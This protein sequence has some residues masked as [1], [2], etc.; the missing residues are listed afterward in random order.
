M[1]DDEE[2][3]CELDLT[4]ETDD[5]RRGLAVYCDAAGVHELR[6]LGTPKAAVVFGYYDPEGREAFVED[7]AELSGEA[8]GVYFTLNPVNPVLLARSVNRLRRFGKPV[9]TS[10]AEII[11]RRW[12]PLDFDPVRP[13]GISSNDAEHEAALA[14]AREVRR[15]LLTLGFPEASMVLADSGNGAHLV[16]RIELANDNGGRDLVKSCLEALAAC[17]SDA[18]VKVDQTTYNAARIWKVPGTLARKGDSTADRPHRLARLLEVP[19]KIAVVPG[20]SLRK[21][22]ALAPP[23]AEPSPRSTWSGGDARF[24][25]DDWIARHELEVEPPKPWNGGRLWV[26][27]TCPWNSQHTHGAAFLMQFANGA[28]AA[29]CHHDSCQG[30]GWHDL[31]EIYEPGFQARQSGRLPPQ[32]AGAPPAIARQ[33]QHTA[34]LRPQSKR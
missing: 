21:L 5:I 9:T 14:R 34:G 11:C 15:Y 18:A 32:M 29:R 25:L 33:F 19:A 27:P 3:E 2:L 6:A 12:L 23:K 13:A 10:D 24:D 17:F 20:E 8:D 22:A 28:V 30:K 7:C 4:D 26:L 16:C 1:N 31:R